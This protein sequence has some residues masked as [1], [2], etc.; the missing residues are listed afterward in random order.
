VKRD[1]YAL[2]GVDR[3]AAAIAGARILAHA[4]TTRRPGVL[5]GI[6]TFGGWFSLL[7]RYNDPVL[8]SSTDGVGTK[9]LLAQQVGRHEGVGLDLVAMCVN[10]VAVH[11]AEPLFL[12]DYVASGVLDVAALDRVMAGIAEG[13]RLAGCALLGGETAQMPGMYREGVY[14]LAGFCVGAVER[15]A[16]VDGSRV[17]VGDAIVGLPSSGLHSN[18]FALARSLIE[19]LSLEE[20]HGL[21][22][23]LGDVL[24][25][26][27]RIYVEPLLELHRRGWLAAA[28]HVTGGGLL[29]N[30]PR[31]LPKGCGA[32]IDRRRWPGQP[33]FE[34]LRARGRL[35]DEEMFGTFNC[36]IGMVVVVAGQHVDAAISAV[37]GHVIGEVVPDPAGACVV[38]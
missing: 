9:L 3:G 12:L 6:G 13:C 27:T 26:P 33:V 11:G 18:G 17:R 25:T 23:P 28:A 2:A 4:E 8:V 31:C 34:W 5:G 36:G 16:L 19:G 21:G 37:G 38:T 32:R 10:D 22:A 29:G 24:L 7:G 14:D 1:P 20:H 30:V 15:E 35:S